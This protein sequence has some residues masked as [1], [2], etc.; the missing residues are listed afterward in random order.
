MSVH[1]PLADV[2]LHRS[3][4]LPVAD[5]GRRRWNDTRADKAAPQAAAV[6]D[7]LSFRMVVGVVYLNV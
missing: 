7:D 2:N 3:R 4:P 1:L 6:R 5:A